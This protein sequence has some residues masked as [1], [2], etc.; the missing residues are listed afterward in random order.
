MPCGTDRG[1]RRRPCAPFSTITGIDGTRVTGPT[2]LT[3]VLETK[4]PGNKV[5]VTWTD[6]QG[7]SHTATVTLGTSPEN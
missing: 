1:H 2:A 6:A 7:Q 5:T 3:D 4:Y